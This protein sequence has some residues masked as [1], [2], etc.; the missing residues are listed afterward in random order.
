[1]LGKGAIMELRQKMIDMLVEQQAC[2]AEEAESLTDTELFDG[3]ISCHKSDIHAL[4]DEFI[5]MAKLKHKYE[6][7]FNNLREF[8][9]DSYAQLTSCEEELDRIISETWG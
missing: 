7:A 5:K 2:S 1:M 8:I 3:I 4:N 6:M 9:E